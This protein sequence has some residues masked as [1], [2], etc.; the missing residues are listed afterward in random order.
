[1]AQEG[2]VARGVMDVNTAL[3]EALDHPRPRW[4][5]H[6]EFVQLPK[7]LGAQPIFVYLHPTAVNLHTSSRWRP[8][9]LNT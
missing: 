4:P 6:V 7:A 5:N 8:S 1:M 2:I 9:V 3:Q